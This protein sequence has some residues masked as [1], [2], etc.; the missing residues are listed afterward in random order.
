MMQD[1]IA[2][3]EKIV[4]AIAAERERLKVELRSAA[5]VTLVQRAEVPKEPESERRIHRTLLSA[6]AGAA[7]PVFVLLLWQ[8][9]SRFAG[10]LLPGA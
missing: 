7:L 1:E 2:A 6:A 3:L 4:E 10:W 9:V 5:R 8:L